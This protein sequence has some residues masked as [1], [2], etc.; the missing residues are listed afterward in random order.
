MDAEQK[1]EEPLQNAHEVRN[2]QKRPSSSASRTNGL[3]IRKKTIYMIVGIL[4]VWFLYCKGYI[5]FLGVSGRHA[6]LTVRFSSNPETDI[7]RITN[8]LK[9][10]G[11]LK[12]GYDK[13]YAKVVESIDEKFDKFGAADSNGSYYILP[14]VLNWISSQGWKFQQKFCINMNDDNAE[15]YFVK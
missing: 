11:M 4:M 7:T 15:Y 1:A 13:E 12:C 5:P 10:G 9:I 2:G 14:A 3:K 6:V 8:T